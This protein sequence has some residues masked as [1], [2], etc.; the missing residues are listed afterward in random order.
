MIQTKVRLGPQA[1]PQ[2]TFLS[3]PADIAIYGGAAF[4]GKTFGLLL[5]PLRHY[6]N[7]KFGGV[8]FRR[9]TPQITN[10]GGLWDTSMGLYSQVEAIPRETK[11]SWKFPSGMRVKFA[12]LEYEKTVHQWQGAQVTM[13][14]FDE[15]THFTLYQFNYVMSRLRGDSGVPGYIRATCNPDPDSFVRILIDWW[16]KGQEYPQPER[17]FPIPERAGKLRWFIRQDEVLRWANSKEELYRLY[18]RGPSIQP[19]SLTFI[20]SSIEDNPIGNR[21]DPTYLSKLLNL[22]K[23][24]KMRLLKGNWDIKATSGDLFDR[25]RFEIIEVLPAGWVDQIR[26]WDKAGTKPNP[27]NPKPDWTRGVKMLK[28]PNGLYVVADMRSCQDEPGEVNKLIKIVATQDG[29]GCRIKEQRDPGQAGKEEGA[30]FIKM[31]GAYNVSIQP[32]SKNKLLR[33]GPLRAQVHERNVKLLKGDWN[34]DFL[35]ELHAWSGED[36]EAD[37][38][39][40]ATSG[41]YNELAGVPTM[42][43]AAVERMGR[44]IGGK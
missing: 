26:F 41:A 31:L 3:T 33:A 25:D 39:V 29:V 38:I 35:N 21:N 37:D 40:D 5:E 6:K 42:D 24:E 10:Q 28:Y 23:V 11:L 32:F 15:L 36:G 16:I 44:A 34:N 14:G 4:G 30:N 17:G 8:I 12:H 18:G 1:G 9:E 27:N 20:P 19:M 43:K 13:F 7:P 2:T 22:P